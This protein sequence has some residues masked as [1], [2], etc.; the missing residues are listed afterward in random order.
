MIRLTT[1]NSS[2]YETHYVAPANIAR[3]TEAAT[4]SQWHGIRSFVRTFDGA[5]LECSEVADDIRRQIAAAGKGG[6]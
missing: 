4:S 3:I 6:T 1:P 2:G 5:V